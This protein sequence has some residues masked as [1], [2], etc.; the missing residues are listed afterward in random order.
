MNKVILNGIDVNESLDK[1]E[2][3][4]DFIAYIK[5]AEQNYR[6]NGWECFGIGLVEEAEYHFGKADSCLATIN[7]LESIIG[8]KE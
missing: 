6:A 8:D 3:V 2:K 7:D 4:K 1:L 5:Q